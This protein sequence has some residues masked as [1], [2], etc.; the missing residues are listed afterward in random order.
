MWKSRSDVPVA[1][2]ALA[3]IIV[4]IIEV[5]INK[6]V[7]LYSSNDNNKTHTARGLTL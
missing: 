7:V 1:R 6:V 4:V 3:I 5:L 2:I